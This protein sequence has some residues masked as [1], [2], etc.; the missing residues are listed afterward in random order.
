M[1]DLARRLGVVF[2]GDRYVASGGSTTTLVSSVLTQ[3]DDYWNGGTLFITYD[4]GGQG[5]APQ[6]QSR[7][8]T[9]FTASNDTVTVSTAFT[10]SVANGDKFAITKDEYP[11]HVM[12]RAIN[13]AL[14]WWGDIVLT[15]DSSITTAADTLE[16]SL[17]SAAVDD[18][19]KVAVATRSSSPYDYEPFPYWSVDKGTGKL[20]FRVMPPS[21]RKVRLVYLAP[22]SGVT[23]DASQIS[24]QVSLPALLHYALAECYWWRIQTVGRDDR[25]WVD[26]YNQCLQLAD[27]YKREF[28]RSTPGKDP[29][30]HF[31]VGPGIGRVRIG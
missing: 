17:P 27:K 26:F 8:I 13:S 29:S 28:P 3:S 21:D 6:N 30:Y 20:V 16:Y 15:D 4:A 22:H 12:L 10:A 5:A 25:K 2:E 31:E 1:L 18:L 23:D 19:R 9:D 24:S 11:R 14:Q 7:E